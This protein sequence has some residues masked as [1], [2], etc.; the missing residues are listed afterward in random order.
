M[1]SQ[2][3]GLYFA[4]NRETGETLH[5]TEVERGLACNCICPSCGGSLVA[6]KGKK[7]E[8]HFA[9]YNT[10]ECKKGFETSIHLFVK[11]VLLTCDYF[12]LPPH[13]FL[14]NP[15]AI[16]FTNVVAEKKYRDIIPDITATVGNK[17]LFI[18]VH[19]FNAVNSEKAV[20]VKEYGI[21]TLEI[22]VRD[23]DFDSS[24]FNRE[25][26]AIKIINSVKSKHWIYNVHEESE[27]KKYGIE[28]ERSGRDQGQME[29]DF[30]EE[31]RLEQEQYES[32]QDQ[33][34]KL[35]RERQERVIEFEENFKK[36]TLQIS[37]IIEDVEREF[38]CKIYYPQICG[39]CSTCISEPR[40]DL[41]WRSFIY[42]GLRCG[43]QGFI[44][45]RLSNPMKINKE[46]VSRFDGLCRCGGER[47]V[48]FSYRGPYLMCNKCQQLLNVK[49]LDFET[50]LSLD[51]DN[52][53][54]KLMSIVHDG[55]S[56]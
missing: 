26:V 30:L 31:Q 38:D 4:T 40:I 7:Q 3:R 48:M 14:N 25:D 50:F 34:S 46:K 5:I 37:S 22:D 24:D 16:K 10:E 43:H 2:C 19:V 12:V 52:A 56:I 9:H 47:L 8:H 55:Y 17:I 45:K 28:Y 41:K 29:Y 33:R 18:E 54:D 21:S 44:G 13:R 1:N 11:D 53:Y 20:K 32:S 15:F 35:Q 23:L 39:G 36:H 6:K 27:M 51:K 42:V 49:I